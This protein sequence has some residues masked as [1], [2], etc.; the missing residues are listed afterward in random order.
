MTCL[1][2]IK[3]KEVVGHNETAT[4]WHQVKDLAEFEGWA[5]VLGLNVASGEDKDSIADG[6]L[7]ILGAQSDFAGSKRKGSQ[8]LNNGLQTS[9]VRGSCMARKSQR[10][11]SQPECP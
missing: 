10:L 6:G 2:I 11:V 9:K 5:S 3:S 1:A 8:L 7:K 4:N